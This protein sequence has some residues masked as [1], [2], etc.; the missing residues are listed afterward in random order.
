M[1][2]NTRFRNG[3]GQAYYRLSL[4]VSSIS[5]FTLE[6]MIISNCA[7]PNVIEDQSQDQRS[8]DIFC[9]PSSVVQAPCHGQPSAASSSSV[10]NDH[11]QTPAS[12]LDQTPSSKPRISS[13]VP[14][15][16]T[17]D[18]TRAD[19]SCNSAPVEQLPSSEPLD[20]VESN[21]SDAP[22]QAPVNLSCNVSTSPLNSAMKVQTCALKKNRTKRIRFNPYVQEHVADDLLPISLA[23][24]IASELDS[25]NEGNEKQ[26]NDVCAAPVDQSKEQSEPLIENNETILCVSQKHN[27]GRLDLNHLLGLSHGANVTEWESVWE[28][29]EEDLKQYE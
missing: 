14:E 7:S 29:Y 22:D 6:R 26:Q 17:K 28:R 23:D 5:V 27:I 18:Q 2:L 8:A 25:L 13:T 15:N 3:F 21:T 1:L 12:T 24:I 10:E 20:E 9:T 19:L 16:Q 11:D 4:Q